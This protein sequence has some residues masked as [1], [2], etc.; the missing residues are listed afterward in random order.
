MP[1]SQESTT[2]SKSPSTS[3]SERQPVRHSGMLLVR[4]AVGMRA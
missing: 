1:T 3:I 4:S 2:T